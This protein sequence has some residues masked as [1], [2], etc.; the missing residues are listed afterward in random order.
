MSEQQK[1]CQECVWPL[2]CCPESGTRQPPR[3]CPK[4]PEVWTR[5]L[6]DVRGVAP[7]VDGTPLGEADEIPVGALALT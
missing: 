6:E 3:N 2:D 7:E 1:E 5:T 4:E